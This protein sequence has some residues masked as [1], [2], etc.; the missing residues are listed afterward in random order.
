MSDALRFLLLP[1]WLDSGPTHWQSRWE[2]LHGCDRVQQDD[3][4]WPRRGDWMARLDDVLQAD[5]RP[6]VL[7]AHS[8]GRPFAPHGAGARC[9]ARCTTR[10]RA[11]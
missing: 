4:L 8:L 11:R 2:A 3:W 7:I 10:Y 6:A 9:A 1:G 5:P